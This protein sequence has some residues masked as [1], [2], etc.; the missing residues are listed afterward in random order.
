MQEINTQKNE[1]EIKEKKTPK[2]LTIFIL[3]IVGN[4]LFYLIII[5]LFLFSIMNINAGSKNGGFPNL[6]GKGFLSV[7]TNSMERNDKEQD[8]VAEWANYKIGEI[9]V[10]DLVWVTKF[11][12]DDCSSLKVGDV[13][14]FYDS[15]LE[16]LNTHRIVYIA[17]DNLSVI[18]QG[19][20]KA[21]LVPFD[22]SDPLGIYNGQ[23][24]LQGDVETVGVS[25]IKGVVTGITRGAGKVMDNIHQNWLWYFVLPILAFLLFEVFMVVRNIMELKGA[26]QKAELATDKEAMIADLEAQKEE[27]RKQILAELQAQQKQEVEENKE[28]STL[29]EKEETQEQV[30]EE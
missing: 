19:D 29:E 11:T 8:D 12:K 22:M 24:D 1:N 21:E 16:A 15:E 26:K 17:E 7:Q 13:I 25:Q 9:N 6:F 30:T 5:G 18:T 20:N 14:T 3:K 27:M 2:E 23:L 10:G 28:E 4:V